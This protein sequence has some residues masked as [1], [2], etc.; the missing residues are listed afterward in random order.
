M[1]LIE[2]FPVSDAGEAHQPPKVLPL[3]WKIR[4]LNGREIVLTRIQQHQTYGGMLCGLPR[5]PEGKVSRAIEEA[6]EWSGDFSVLPIVI[7]AT[8][9]HGVRQ[10]PSD[11]QFAHVEPTE[12]SMLPQVTTY[13]QFHS[14]NTALDIDERGTFALL[15]WWQSHFGIPVDNDLL[16]RLQS[17]DWPKGEV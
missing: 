13:A 1:R 12:W 14:T 15:V 4:Q 10:T 2:T 7:P 3:D 9:L 16:A 17:L 6:R 11:P 8:I 5:D